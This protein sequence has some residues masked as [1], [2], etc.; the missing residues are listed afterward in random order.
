MV[1]GRTLRFGQSFWTPQTECCLHDF[2]DDA[3][4][5]RL[6]VASALVQRAV[7]YASERGM[8]PVWVQAEADDAKAAALYGTL[9]HEELAIGHFG[10]P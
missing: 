1:G 6:G 5:R 7:T 9:S 8:T 3:G 4:F 2:A 10:L